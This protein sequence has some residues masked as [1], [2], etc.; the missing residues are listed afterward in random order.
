MYTNG[1]HDY[2]HRATMPAIFTTDEPEGGVKSVNLQVGSKKK[3]FERSYALAQL[4]ADR[5]ASRRHDELEKSGKTC[6]EVHA[7]VSVHLYT[8]G[9]REYYCKLDEHDEKSYSLEEPL[10]TEKIKTVIPQVGSAFEQGYGRAVAST[11]RNRWTELDQESKISKSCK[12]TRSPMANW[13]SMC[14][15]ILT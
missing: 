3:Q 5:K 6:G 8:D 2:Y 10:G 1:E 12:W 13:R 11:A 4:T 7:V 15:A 9:E 14:G